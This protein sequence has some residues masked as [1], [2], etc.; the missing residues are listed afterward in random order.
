MA[1]V[2][3]KR[4]LKFVI[5]CNL[6]F[7]VDNP[8][9]FWVQMRD[10][11]VKKEIEKIQFII[12][13]NLYHF[14]HFS[15]APETG[16]IVIAPYEINSYKSHF[17]AIVEGHVT[18]PEILVQ[19]FFI[20]YGYSSECRLCDLKRLNVDEIASIPALAME[21]VLAEIQ[22]SIVHNLS[23][24]WSEAACDFFWMLANKPGI[25]FG[26]IY[27]IV[28]GVISL[29]LILKHNNEEISINQSLLDKGFAIDKQEGYFSRFNHDLR[30][31]QSDMSD[32]QC[33]HYEQLQ[34]NQDY[35]PDIY[36]EPPSDVEC[37]TK[38]TLRGPFSPLEIEL[39]HLTVAGRD[40]R[41]NMATNSVNS[42][43]LDTDPEDCHQRLL[44]AGSV[45]QNAHGS[46][47][48]VYNTTLMPRL[49]G[50]TA[51]II[52]IF[53]PC[54]ELRRNIFGTYYIGALCGLGSDPTTKKSLFPEHDIEL[55]FDA[56]ITIDDLQYVSNLI[57]LFLSHRI[58]FLI[59][60]LSYR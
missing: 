57:H 6:N 30:L 37:Y 4:M 13:R 53:T 33:Y 40:K 23:D 45:S 24:T 55:Q 5:Q 58:F 43:L 60:F 22:P 31:K 41:V 17:R 48:S 32:E 2:K 51:L 36:P 44:V 7:Q 39:K 54:M 27:S 28:N 15:T 38:V 10:S 16:T 42:V 35:M 34:Y 12:E 25:L 9:R 18:S 20:D 52:L 11:K 3:H 8:G 1:T 49:S 50:L 56:E 26:E 59:S 19:V 29:E 21:C 14:G 47:L 46:N